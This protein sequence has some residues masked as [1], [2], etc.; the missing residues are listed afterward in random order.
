MQACKL[1]YKLKRILYRCGCKPSTLWSA[2]KLADPLLTTLKEDLKRGLNARVK[3]QRVQ[4]C[5]DMLKLVNHELDWMVWMDEATV[6]FNI[7]AIKVIGRKGHRP[8][9]HD[10]RIGKPKYKDM[11]ISFTVAVN[12]KVGLVHLHINSTTTHCRLAGQFKVR[13]WSINF[14]YNI[15]FLIT[16]GV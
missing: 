6:C 7:P 12:A 10:P 9:V 3:A 8:V 2:A 1:N 16:A 11:K 5:K 15:F 4:Y 13:L 14:S